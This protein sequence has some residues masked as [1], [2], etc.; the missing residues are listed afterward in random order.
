[1]NYKYGGLM[2]I[3]EKEK[4]AGDDNYIIH[5]IIY[6]DVS[7]TMRKIPDDA[8]KAQYLDLW[9]RTRSTLVA[10]DSAYN[11]SNSDLG[12]YDL[13]EI[14]FPIILDWTIGNLSCS[15]AKEDMSSFACKE[16]SKCIESENSSGYICKC[17]DGYD[18]NP[19]L[20]NG[21]QVS[22]QLQLC[23]FGGFEGDDWK[24]GT[25]CNRPIHKR[26]PVNI[27][28][29]RQI[30]DNTLIA[31]EILHSLKTTKHCKQGNFALKLHMSK[32]YDR[33]EWV[34]WLG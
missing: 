7:L 1:M 29:G 15:E 2:F 3:L 31:Y 33:V 27:A 9:P 13:K 23:K 6:T 4:I 34:F 8:S 5:P 14:Q 30:F 12:G 28:L 16:N 11:F 21:C 17:C 10:K 26:S 24:N 22:G 18:G 20:T 25:G 19:Y 32:A